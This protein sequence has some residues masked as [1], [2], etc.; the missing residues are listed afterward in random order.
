MLYVPTANL[1]VNG[2]LFGSSSLVVGDTV[3][4]NGSRVN[5][6]TTVSAFPGFGHAVLAE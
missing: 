3:T 1:T 6:P 4:L 2:A 5:I